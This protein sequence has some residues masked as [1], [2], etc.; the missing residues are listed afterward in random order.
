M[1]QGGTKRDKP[2]QGQSANYANYANWK[3]AL[4]SFGTL[5]W[6]DV[7]MKAEGAVPSLQPMTPVLNP[8]FTMDFEFQPTT[9]PVTYVCSD[10]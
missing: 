1:G 10:L 9:E 5:I 4:E 8:I 2:G 7:A 6:V 3:K